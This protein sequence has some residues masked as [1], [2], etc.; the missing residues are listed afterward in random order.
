MNINNLASDTFLNEFAGNSSGDNFRFGDVK[1]F[2]WRFIMSAN[3]TASPP[4]SPTIE[5]FAISY[6]FESTNE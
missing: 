3:T 6:R 1:F 5:S 4:V 2:N